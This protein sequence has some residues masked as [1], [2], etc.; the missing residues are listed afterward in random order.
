MG[1]VVVDSSSGCS[2]S[3]TLFLPQ[4][5]KIIIT[6]QNIKHSKP[7]YIPVLPDPEAL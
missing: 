3:K 4:G 1:V 6:S 5:A 2:G 7:N